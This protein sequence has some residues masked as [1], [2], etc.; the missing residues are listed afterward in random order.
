[1]IPVQYKISTGLCTGISHLRQGLPCQDRIAVKKTE[2][3]VAGVLADGAGS[4]RHSDI[5]ADCVTKAAA[6]LLFAH[7][8][9]LWLQKPETRGKRILNAC[10]QALCRQSYPVCDMACTLLFFA[11]HQDGRFLAGHLGD[12]VIILEQRNELSVFSRPENGAQPNETFFVTSADALM[13]LRIYQ[14]RWSGTGAF[15]LMSDGTADSLYHYSDQMPAAACR[16]IASWLRNGSEDVIS[17]ALEMNMKQR[18]SANTADDMSI[19]VCSWSD[20]Q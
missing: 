5:G 11:A 16:T 17:Q 19:L 20:E 13:H 9:S 4:C 12:G 8:E 18:L 10:M 2:T 7:F 3:V 14:G 15:F 6:D 1:M